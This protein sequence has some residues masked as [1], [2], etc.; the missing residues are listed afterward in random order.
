MPDYA[1]VTSLYSKAAERY[2][3]SS[4]C[5]NREAWQDH[6]KWLGVCENYI[7][8]RGLFSARKQIFTEGTRKGFLGTG[9]EQMLAL[10]PTIDR[11]ISDFTI[12]SRCVANLGSYFYNWGPKQLFS[13][14]SAI[15]FSTT[16]GRSWSWVWIL[17]HQANSS[18]NNR[19][20]IS[21]DAPIRVKSSFHLCI[22]EVW[23]SWWGIAAACSFPHINIRVSA[24]ITTLRG[25]LSK[26]NFCTGHLE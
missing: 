1:G 8:V 4:S 18:D 19:L 21:D 26:D 2:V 14:V 9:L 24:P 16:V 23:F 7:G 25:S 10:C 15:S 22:K 3:V 17:K 20:E 13:V 6:L 5:Y 12:A 11:E